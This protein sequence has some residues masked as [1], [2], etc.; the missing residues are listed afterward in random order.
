MSFTPDE[1][2]CGADALRR[3][4]QGGRMLRNWSDLPNGTRKKWREKVG[5]VLAAIEREA[6]RVN[7]LEK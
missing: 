6:L 3:Y 2:D 5:V 1:I 7:N 4:E